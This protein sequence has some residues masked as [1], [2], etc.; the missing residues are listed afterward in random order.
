MNVAADAPTDG[1]VMGLLIE[2]TRRFL[3]REVD[4]AAIEASGRIPD[5]V[6]AAAASAGLF[7]LTIPESHGGLGLPLRSAG[8]IVAELARVDR[9][10]ATMVGLHAGLGTRSLVVHGSE[11]RRARWLPALAEGERVGAFGA[12]EAGAGSDLQAIRTIARPEGSGLRIDGEK[13]YVT[14]GG[15]AG[16]YTLLVRTPGLGGER[17]FSMVCVPRETPGLSVGPEEDKLGIRA[18]ST[19]T[20]R[21]DD[22]YVPSD[23]LLGAPGAGMDLAHEALGW[24]RVV[25]ATGC[26]GTARYALDATLAHVTARRQFHRPIG[27]FDAARLQVSTM[28]AT[29]F[30]MESLAD[31]AASAAEAGGDLTGLSAAAKVFCSEGAFA[32]CDAALQL[33]GAMGFLEQTGVARALRDCRIT[34]IFEGANDVLLVHLGAGLLV[35]RARPETPTSGHPA[36]DEFDHRLARLVA[37][38]RAEFGVRGTQR[39]L[40]TSRLA[41]AEVCALAARAS[42]DRAATEPES[43]ELA[44]FAVEQLTR[45]GHRQLDALRFIQEDERAAAS[46][47]KRAYSPW[48]SGRSA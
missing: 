30:A 18:S 44:A 22:V 23:H 47:S 17:S 31:R 1:E 20:V 43:A 15:F 13:S 4:P 29:L 40:L 32:I 10:V 41:R 16:L 39:Q 19:V 45:E 38:N 3:A 37:E 42:L 7:A 2:E 21:L 11:A 25:M 26:T 33:H 48:A 36:F 24:G 27:D 28:A 14:N 5:R 46:L 12:T 9:S 6:V 34:R 8:T 35:A